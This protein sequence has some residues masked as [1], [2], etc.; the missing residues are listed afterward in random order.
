[1]DFDLSVPFP[2]ARGLKPKFFTVPAKTDE[3]PG[4]VEL[5]ELDSHTINRLRWHYDWRPSDAGNKG[6]KRDELNAGE[7]LEIGLMQIEILDGR[8][9]KKPTRAA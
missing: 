9:Q 5:D 2:T 3:G 6:K 8:A 7:I 1:M 4:V